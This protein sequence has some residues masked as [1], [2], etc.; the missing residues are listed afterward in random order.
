M[1]ETDYPHSDSS[2][3]NTQAIVATQ[4]ADVPPA[5]ADAMTFANAAALYRHPL[6]VELAGSARP[7]ADR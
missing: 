5:E 7:V 1:Y 2:W 3:P 6:P 4:L